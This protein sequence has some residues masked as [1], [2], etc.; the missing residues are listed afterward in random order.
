L[1]ALSRFQVF[2]LPGDAVATLAEAM[3]AARAAG[4][5]WAVSNVLWWQAF[6]HVFARDRP[7]LAEPVLVELDEL[8]ARAESVS[9]RG[10]SDIVRQIAAA[11]AGRL[12]GARQFMESALAAAESCGDVLLESYAFAYGTDTLIALGD[13]AFAERAVL[14]TV[15]RL[16]RHL[17]ACRQGVVEFGLVRIALARGDLSEAARWV[18]EMRTLM[19]TIGLPFGLEWLCAAEGRLALEAGDL[20]AAR[21]FFHEAMASATATGVPWSQ[22]HALHDLGLLAV[23]EGDTG[24]AED[25]FHRALALD[26]EYGFAGRATDTLEALAVVAASNESSAEAVRLLAAAD[27]LRLATGQVRATL[28]Q[29]RHDAVL[30]ALRAEVPEDTFAQWWTEGAGLS[31][32]DVVAWASRARGERKRPSSGWAALTPTELDVV[33]LAATGATNAEI[34]V[35]LFMSATT[36]KTHLQHVYAKLGVANRAALAA[37]ASR[38]MHGRE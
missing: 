19:R 11:R 12:A 15:A 8:A 4:D 22:A 38:R 35:K 21:P 2:G 17:D 26:V 6:H 16:R 3:A 37:E 10:W 30:A 28:N 34:G 20:P 5:E 18:E 24:A 25:C 1:A 7:E 31:L 9:C 27:G 32:V 23:V 36:A 29:P 14:R 33:A 13:Y